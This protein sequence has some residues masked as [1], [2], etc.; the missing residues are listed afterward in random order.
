MDTRQFERAMNV[1][2]RLA[3]EDAR[4]RGHDEVCSF[5][6]TQSLDLRWQRVLAGFVRGLLS[7]GVAAAC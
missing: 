4:Y 6:A 1:L 3:E 7:R 5:A 2:Q